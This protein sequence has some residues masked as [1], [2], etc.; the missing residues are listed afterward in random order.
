MPE[1][2]IEVIIDEKT[3]DFDLDLKGFK[4]DGCKNIAKA[5]ERMG[6]VTNETVKAEFYEGGGGSNVSVGH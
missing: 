3:G 6:K 4:G 2:I 5:F 1:R